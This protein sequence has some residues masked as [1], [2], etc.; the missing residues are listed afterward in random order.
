[1]VQNYTMFNKYPP[2]SLNIV[3]RSKKKSPRLFIKDS[4]GL[5]FTVPFTYTIFRLVFY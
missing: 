2:I 3:N 5:Q 1:M 4:L